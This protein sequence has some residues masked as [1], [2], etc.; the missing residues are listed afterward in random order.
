MGVYRRPRAEHFGNGLQ[1]A[2]TVSENLVVPK[3][4]NTPALC[5]QIRVSAIVIV[6]VR[7][8]MLTPIS[9]NDQPRF[10]AGEIDDI[11]RYGKLTAETPTQAVAA[12]FS[13]QHSLGVGHISAQVTRLISLGEPTAHI[14]A[15]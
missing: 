1:Y 8:V 4:E 13:P 2:G 5:S 11:G 6:I 14:L 15:A 3:T 12:Q 7:A 9:F 10:K